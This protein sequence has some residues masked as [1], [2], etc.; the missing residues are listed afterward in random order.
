VSISPGGAVVSVRGDPDT[1]SR[2]W[3]V[4]PEGDCIHQ[5][6]G[7]E[8]SPRLSELS[9]RERERERERMNLGTLQLSINVVSLNLL[10]IVKWCYPSC[11]VVVWDEIMRKILSTGQSAVGFQYILHRE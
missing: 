7:T 6:W 8:W 5:W 10:F 4:A 1:S 11:R 3:E 9:E 2:A